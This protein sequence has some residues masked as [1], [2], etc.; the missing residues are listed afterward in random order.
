[1]G[2][3]RQ[4]LLLSTELGESVRGKTLTPS[5]Y[6]KGSRSNFAA[7]SGISLDFFWPCQ[8]QNVLS[9]LQETKFSLFC[10]RRSL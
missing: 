7:I 9:S 2:H 6:C 10:R 3:P 5:N 1:M 8:K 4:S